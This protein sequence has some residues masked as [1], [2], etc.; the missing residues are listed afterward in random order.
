[1]GIGQEMI[2]MGV[3]SILWGRECDYIGKKKIAGRG[4]KMRNRRVLEKWALWEK[5]YAPDWG[6]KA[7]RRTE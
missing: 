5:K 6:E 1:M 2:S 4:L 3:E 7:P